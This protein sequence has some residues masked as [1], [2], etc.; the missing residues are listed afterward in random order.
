MKGGVCIWAKWGRFVIFAV[1][2]LLAFGDTALKSWFLLALGAPAS[3][4]FDTPKYFKTRKPQ[5]DK[6]TLFLWGGGGGT[7]RARLFEIF[8]L[9]KAG[10]HKDWEV[11]D[12]WQETDK[13]F[14]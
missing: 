4:H 3:G 2:R 9:G 1:L 12:V 8:S 5:N 7:S 10:T 11:F 13:S 14:A 6:S